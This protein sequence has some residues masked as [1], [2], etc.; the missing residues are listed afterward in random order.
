MIESFR[1]PTPSDQG[2]IK[3]KGTGFG[4]VVNTLWIAMV[5]I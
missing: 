1:L 2:Y 5:S 4:A 3:D